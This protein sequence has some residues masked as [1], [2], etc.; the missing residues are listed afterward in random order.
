MT[1]LNLPT[2]VTFHAIGWVETTVGYDEIPT[3]YNDKNS[4]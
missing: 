1:A 2:Q 4:C 3:L